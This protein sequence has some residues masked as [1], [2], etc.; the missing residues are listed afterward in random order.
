M[1]QIKSGKKKG[2]PEEKWGTVIHYWGAQTTITDNKVL[3]HYW[4]A[5]TIFEL[6]NDNKIYIHKKVDECLSN[7]RQKNS[8]KEKKDNKL[9]SEKSTNLSHKIV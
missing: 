5:Q 7:R 9:Y 4:G 3:I 6:K 8:N 2:G 1:K